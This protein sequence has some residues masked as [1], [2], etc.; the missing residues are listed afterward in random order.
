LEGILE[1]IIPA[2]IFKYANLPHA[3]EELQNHFNARLLGRAGSDACSR[4][5]KVQFQNPSFIKAKEIAEIFQSDAD[6]L[7]VQRLYD[8]YQVVFE[9]LNNVA[10]HANATEAIITID[11]I[12]DLFI[13]S[14]ND[15]GT[16][17]LTENSS[18]M[19]DMKNRAEDIGGTIEW[20]VGTS[21]ERGT[22][23]SVVLTVPIR[24]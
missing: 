6:S 4:S 3:L 13:V 8:I 9:A 14:V 11:I 2:S 1:D 21:S 12:E 18:G 10:K 23:T 7:T 17:L 15:D 24:S 19:R 16:G 5:L 22:G 20:T